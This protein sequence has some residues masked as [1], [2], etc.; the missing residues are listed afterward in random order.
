MCLSNLGLAGD[1]KIYEPD[2]APFS[3]LVVDR[4]N[5][6]GDF[7]T[8]TVRR[9]QSKDESLRSDRQVLFHKYFTSGSLLKKCTKILLG[10]DLIPSLF[11][12][13]SFIICWLKKST[14]QKFNF[15]KAYMDERDQGLAMLC[16]CYLL[17][18]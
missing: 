13:D 14:H 9:V 5:L 16:Y 7:R 2:K 10:S 18:F 6:F 8:L 11:N 3:I 15:Q 17:H 1:H 12:T 4:I